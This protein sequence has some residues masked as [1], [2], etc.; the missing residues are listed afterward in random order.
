MDHQLLRVKLQ[1]DASRSIRSLNERSYFKANEWRVLAFYFIIPIFKAHLKEKYMNNLVKYLIFLRILCQEKINLE[2]LKHAQA[3]FE[4]FII[5][6]ENIYGRDFMTFNLHAHLHLVKQVKRFGPLNSISCFPFENVFRI[7][8][9]MF[10]GSRN[11]EGQIARNLVRSKLIKFELD[12]LYKE[13]FN[14]DLRNYLSGY[15]IKSNDSKPGLI[16]EKKI[17]Y[18]NLKPYEKTLINNKDCTVLYQSHGAIINKNVYYTYDY[19][20]KNNNYNCYTVE[21]K[22]GELDSYGNIV[23]FV[24]LEKDLFVII[25]I[26]KINSNNGFK[27]N[28]LDKVTTYYVNSFYKCVD[29]TNE[30]VLV[31]LN[32]IK[33][34]CL[35]IQLNNTYIITPIINT[36]EHD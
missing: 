30:Y 4:D 20:L 36:F 2:N 26:F 25:N 15:L 22:I 14:Y 32:T 18:S 19:S 21:F 5:E 27:F 12:N 29:Y 28:E 33:K 31:A 24:R 23:N 3:I 7:T 16:N 13:T 35:F 1:I 6:F 11:F 8:R 10:H 17:S 9:E 34:I